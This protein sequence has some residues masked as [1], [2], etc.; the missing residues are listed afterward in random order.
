MQGVVCRQWGGS[1]RTDTCP[2][3]SPSWT[4]E[5][6]LNG[7]AISAIP[8]K[9]HLGLVSDLGY[10]RLWGAS[11]KMTYCIGAAQ[12]YPKYILCLPSGVWDRG[13]WN[14]RWGA[15]RHWGCAQPGRVRSLH[16]SLAALP[17][18]G[19]GCDW[20]RRVLRCDLGWHV[21]RCDQ[22]WHVLWCDPSWHVPR[23]DPGW[24]VPWHGWEQQLPGGRAGARR[25]KGRY[26]SHGSVTVSPRSAGPSGHRG[27]AWALPFLWELPATTGH[28]CKVA[29]G[30]EASALDAWRWPRL[31]DKGVAPGI[32]MHK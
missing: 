22:G 32:N 8:G 21:L 18:A 7:R 24:R 28:H 15:R 23:C 10:Q 31:G 16:P 20:G 6:C 19:T 12:K 11:Q 30:Q 1:G 27:A 17:T 29:S 9:R 13:S 26:L 3:E 2:C 25:G 14:G 5:L 4:T